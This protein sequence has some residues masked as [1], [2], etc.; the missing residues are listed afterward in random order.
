MAD[1]KENLAYKPTKA[2]LKLLEVLVNP[3]HKEKNVVDICEI[4][5]ISQRHYYDIFK[6]QAFIEYYKQKSFDLVKQSVMPILNAVVKEAKAGS[7]HHAK[8]ILEMGDMYT[9]K[10]KQV[11]TGA[12]DGPLNVVFHMPRPKGD[13]HADD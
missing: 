13:A 7:Y 6:K 1:A 3:E 12:D 5:G 8:L 11:V 10:V 2:E 4:A 9:E